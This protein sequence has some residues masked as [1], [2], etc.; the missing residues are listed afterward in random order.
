[1]VHFERDPV[2]N[3]KQIHIMDWFSSDIYCN[4]VAF[5]Y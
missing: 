3:G 4:K 5:D 2:I 1:M